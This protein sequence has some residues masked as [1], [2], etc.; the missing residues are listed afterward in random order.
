MTPEYERRLKQADRSVTLVFVTAVVVAALVACAGVTP[1]RIALN[2]LQG[3]RDSVT[4]SLKVFNAGY[5]ANQP[6]FGEIQRTKLQTLYGKYL[7][8]DK[9]AAE[10]LAVTTAAN[11]T[12]LV[13]SVTVLAA[14][15]IRGV[16][17]LQ[18]AAAPTPATAPP[19]P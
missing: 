18:P 4:T 9:V 14:D 3:I 19:H 16:Q 10:A 5:Q 15:V 6:G 8:A 13:A 1:Q 17:S 2:S 7:A 11:Q 12:D